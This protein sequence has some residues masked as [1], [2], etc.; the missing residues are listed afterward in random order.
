MDD[1]TLEDMGHNPEEVDGCELVCAEDE[2]LIADPREKTWY[3]LPNDGVKPMKCPGGF[4]TGKIKKQD[5][6]KQ[7]VFIDL[8]PKRKYKI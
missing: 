8:T 7:I 1:D 2:I 4:K 6:G 5:Q 3:C